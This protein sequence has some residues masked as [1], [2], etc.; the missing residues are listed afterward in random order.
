M[1]EAG[2]GALAG[3]LVAA[4]VIL[5]DSG[6]MRG[7]E[8]LADSKL[9]TPIA[10]QRLFKR[11]LESAEAWSF[12]CVAPRD[13]DEYGLQPANVNAMREAVLS[14]QPSPDMVI[15]DYYRIHDLGIPQWSMAHGDRACRCVA[16]ASVLAK[17]IRDRLMT[18]WSL[19]HP[20]Y[21]FESNKGY[22]TAQHL[23]ALATHGPLACHRRTFHGVLQM[24][25]ELECVDEDD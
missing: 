22:G 9:L 5:P 2:R 3:P 6:E 24:E 20:E 7:L 23:K 17:V 19:Y 16:A 14:L 1:D 8:E 10:R 25:M 15:V 4:A 12:S 21:G 18:H 11:I 13:I